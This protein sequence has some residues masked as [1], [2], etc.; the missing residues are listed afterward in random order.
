MRAQWAGEGY[1][2]SMLFLATA[3]SFI[4]FYYLDRPQS[5][6]K[7]YMFSIIAITACMILTFLVNWAWSIKAQ[8]DT[9][10]WP[11]SHYIKGS[12]LND[13]GITV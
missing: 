7:Q 8:F 5:K 1:L 2:A 10:F 3:V 13:Q 12:L 11:P 9:T 6:S 4:S